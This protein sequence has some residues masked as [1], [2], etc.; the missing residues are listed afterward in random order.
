VHLSTAL[1]CVGCWDDLVCGVSAGGDAG[2]AGV[3]GGGVSGGAEA[4]V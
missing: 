1:L 3:G 2:G 4:V